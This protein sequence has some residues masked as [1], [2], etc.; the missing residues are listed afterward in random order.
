[1]RLDPKSPAR[2]E[3]I[4]SDLSPG[5]AAECFTG[6][7]H[8]SSSTTT[9]HYHFWVANKWVVPSAIYFFRQ[10]GFDHVSFV[11]Y[12]D[13]EH[14]KHHHSWNAPLRRDVLDSSSCYQ[15]RNQV[16]NIS[17]G[18]FHIGVSLPRRKRRKKR[19][20][21]KASHLIKGPLFARPVEEI[22][23]RELVECAVGFV[24]E[25]EEIDGD[26][27][28]LYPAVGFVDGEEEEEEEEALDGQA[29]EG[30]EE[31]DAEESLHDEH[32]DIGIMIIQVCKVFVCVCR[33]VCNSSYAL[34]YCSSFPTESLA[35]LGCC[36]T[37]QVT[38]EASK[39]HHNHP[40]CLAG[41]CIETEGVCRC[42]S[43]RR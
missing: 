11:P 37:L 1:M 20:K 41:L 24:E 25:E 33:C 19:N 16:L 6:V 21:M 7:L 40:T 2:F 32:R 8:L 12:A 5:D 29:G 22:E 3:Q 42:S 23:G 35:A 26:A 34:L 31:E 15:L 30:K 27:I 18:N 10:N 9:E 4:A 39:F 17:G 28:V 14:Y 13:S 36:E 38:L 43:R